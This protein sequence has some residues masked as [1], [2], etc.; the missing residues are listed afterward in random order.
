MSEQLSEKERKDLEI[1][2]KFLK[3]PQIKKE[4][5][6][7]IV[8]FLKK[9]GITSEII[10]AAFKKHTQKEQ[11]EKEEKSDKISKGIKVEIESRINRAQITNFLTLKGLNLSSLKSEVII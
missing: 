9:K 4:S 8:A 2:I 5:K 3:N 11:I 10:E 1:T 6:E 7:L